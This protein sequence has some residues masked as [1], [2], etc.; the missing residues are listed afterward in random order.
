MLVPFVGADTGEKEAYYQSVFAQI[1][2]VVTP[3]GI[4]HTFHANDTN[5]FYSPF[6]WHI[7]ATA[8]STINSGAYVRLLFSGTFLNFMFD[9]TNMV[10]PTS[11]LY[12]RVD[13][14]PATVSLVRPRVTVVI[15]PNNT[16][17]TVPFHTVELMVKST[18]ERANRWAS[19]GN[20]TR[21]ILTGIETD[22]SIAPWI[23]SDVNVLIYGDSITEGVL[24]LGGSQKYDTDHNDAK[25]VYSFVLG[26]LLGAEVGVVGFGYNALTHPGSGGVPPLGEA[27]NQ[28]WESVPRSFTTPRPDLIVLNEGTND[29]C[30]VTGPG[31]VGTDISVPLAAVLNDLSGACPGIPIA[32]LLPFN[33]GQAGHILAVIKQV[34][35][36][37]IHFINTTGFYDLHYGGSLH[38][39]GPN[40]VA[41][42][43][44]QIARRL[45][46]L[47]AKSIL[48]RSDSI[49]MAE[50]PAAH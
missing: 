4:T 25:M 48:S 2:P 42:I 12:W 1:P 41:R 19:S 45:R 27:W 34:D 49:P 22:G 20:S 3:S 35:S 33:G 10:T 23:P 8:A 14:G 7:N 15:P 47:L 21:V 32:V 38:P 43:A 29:G 16:A 30:D 37:H 39:T 9:V 28:L 13:N 46:P 11:E 24:T 18:T 6:V 17:N 50:D 40:D 44:P 31:C 26:R 5:L 36:P